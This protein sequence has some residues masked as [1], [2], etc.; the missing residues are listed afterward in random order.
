LFTA[1]P[2]GRKIKGQFQ[3]KRI[4][5]SNDFIK[6][7]GIN[8]KDIKSILSKY[9]AESRS[10]IEK[11]RAAESTI[12]SVM[13]SLPTEV[14][15]ETPDTPWHSIRPPY[16]FY[17]GDSNT[18]RSGTATSFFAYA[19]HEGNSLTGDISCLSQNVIYEGDDNAVE[20]TTNTSNILIYFQMPATGRLNIWS[21]MLCIES[22]YNGYLGDDWGWSD[23]SIFQS[24][25]YYMSV[26]EQLGIE[27]AYFTLLYYYGHSDGENVE[28][29]GNMAMR[30]DPKAFNL[31][32]NSVYP[33]GKWI[34]MR[35]GI[36]DHQVATIDDMSS[37][38]EIKNHWILNGVFISA[39]YP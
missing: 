7:V 5:D 25:K 10:V 24:S 29:S 18:W 16:F 1:T 34:R 15:I 20:V 14:I 23:G 6:S 8:P 36:I 27:E 13:G 39:I 12:E 17:Y 11:S 9:Q 31:N 38:G 32:T 2:E 28:W 3:K 21:Q 26:G 37:W 4:S 22:S 33:A 30:G 19:G 35:A